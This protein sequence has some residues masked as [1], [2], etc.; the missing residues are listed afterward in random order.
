MPPKMKEPAAR[1]RGKA[2]HRAISHRVG[3]SKKQRTASNRR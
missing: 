2:H 3:K 1:S